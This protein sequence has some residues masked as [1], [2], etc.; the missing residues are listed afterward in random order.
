MTLL[1]GYKVLDFGRYIAGPYCA[2]LL[3]DH[4]ADVIRIEKVS[5]SEDR[6]VMPVSESATDGAMFMQMNRNKRAMT[7]NPMKPEGREIVRKLV[8]QA[9]VVVANLPAAGLRTMGLNYESLKAIKPDIILTTVSTFG[10]TGP[11]SDRVGFDGLGQVMSGGPHLT[12]SADTPT[13]DT[14]PIVDYGSA[15]M[16]AFGTVT[17]LLHRER[18]GEGQQVEGALLHTALTY[19][20]SYLIEQSQTAVN[21]VATN[22]RSQIAGPADIIKTVD[23]WI[24]VQVIG[25]PLFE[26]WVTMIGKP[27]LLQDN[28][29][30]D[31][32]QR[33]CHG[34]ALSALAQEHALTLTT[35][36]ALEAYAAAS[37]PA[38]PVYTPQQALDDEHINAAGFVTP[39]VTADGVEVPLISAP[40]KMS[41]MPEEQATAAPQL[42]EH[43]R[44]ILHDMGYTENQIDELADAR[45]I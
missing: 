31:D 26:R 43:T 5:G 45:V 25:Q 2:A 22:N 23:G 16:S 37:V 32:E 7:L 8:E 28:R 9:D 14:L 21:R 10:S 17:A 1:S 30:A 18:T 39:V 38:G 40:I 4:G 6:F 36:Q 27:E 13:R 33:G 11:Y 29:F 41:A 20:S 34:E 12:G 35:S 15:M 19:A 24:M 44:E 3:A 42:G